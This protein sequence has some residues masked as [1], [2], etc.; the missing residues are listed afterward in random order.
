[1]IVVIIVIIIIVV[2]VTLTGRRVAIGGDPYVPEYVDYTTGV[3]LVTYYGIDAVITSRLTRTTITVEVANGK[4]CSSIRGITFQVPNGAR[5]A[6]LATIAN[7]Q[8]VVQGQVKP[9]QDARDIFLEQ[10]QQGLN[11]AYIEE[12]SDSFTHNLQVAMPPLGVTQVVVVLEQLLEQKLGKVAFAIPFAPNEQVDTIVLDVTVEDLVTIEDTGDD[13]TGGDTGGPAF[14][15]DLGPDIT[16]TMDSD[17][18]TTGTTTTLPPEEE[19]EPSL[20]TM[21][22][23]TAAGADNETTAAIGNNRHHR[24]LQQEVSTGD[25]TLGTMTKRSS[26]SLNLPDAREY[27]HLPTIVYG[28][29]TP[30]DIPIQGLLTTDSQQTCFEH[31]FHPS[32]L[33]P[34][35]RKVQ[36]VIDT[37]ESMGYYYDDGNDQGTESTK[38]YQTKEAI[39]KF[40]DST[41][42]P[43]DTLTIQTFARKGTE[44]L[45]GSAQMSEEEKRDAKDFLDSLVPTRHW[46]AN[47]QEAYLEGLLRAKPSLVS[48]TK[49]EDEENSEK[50]DTVTI[51]VMISDTWSSNYGETDR[52]VIAQD[53]YKLNAAGQVKIFSL[54][55][56]DT[57]DMDLLDAIAIMNGGVA[58]P[59]YERS[60]YGNITSQMTSFFDSEFGT[61]LLSDVEIV[62]DTTTTGSGNSGVQVHGETQS[63]FPLLADGYELVVR[64]LLGKKDGTEGGGGNSPT[65]LR[66]ITTAAT[67]EGIQEW[68]TTAVAMSDGDDE[69][70]TSLCFQSYA[71]ARIT[72]LLRLGEAAKFVKNDDLIAELVKLSEPCN[73]EK[74][75]NGN[76]NIAKCI[77]KEALDLALEA[78][79]VVKGLTGMVTIDEDGC[80][81]F[82]EET[83][84]CTEGS[85]SNGWRNNDD[86]YYGDE[87]AGDYG[88]DGGAPPPVYS[89]GG[90]S[91][92]TSAPTG[93]FD[94]GGG[95]DYASYNGAAPVAAPG[96]AVAKEG[97]YAYASSSAGWNMFTHLIV[98][99]TLIF[100]WMLSI[101]N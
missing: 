37:S 49:D 9:L 67:T 57:A 55:F 2:A 6:S 29:Y 20:A 91:Y 97:G 87:E 40:I 86:Y 10:A 83:E 35:K 16:F 54:G 77:E 15:L 39:K 34:M 45:W 73:N 59:I 25:N 26:Y 14:V 76:Y 58:A 90:G 28:S 66:A 84:I 50:D 94:G 27:Q 4:D 23:T 43:N 60:G 100:A 51:L 88:Y 5:V 79:V 8:C 69:D 18:S 42:T 11:S 7:E 71:H 72:Q 74:D 12:S 70:G 93:G 56:A 61:V 21:V 38:L 98:L 1:M 52:Q 36:F 44:R 64:G 3:S 65:A 31:Y 80:L 46:S 68:T 53:V 82:E 62:V 101:M 81:S 99:Q 22:P 33:N 78:K 32:S 13:D 24:F 17:T 85:S 75:I 92:D 48:L 19:E 89:G 30:A 47:I 63:K 95:A 96:E 41:L